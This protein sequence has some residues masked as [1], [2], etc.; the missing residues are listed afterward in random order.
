MMDHIFQYSGLLTI[1]SFI[2]LIFSMILINIYISLAKKLEFFSVP[3]QGGVRQ[4]IIPTSGGISFGLAYILMVLLFNNIH[5][6]PQD[7]L[8][9]IV[10]GSGLM[11][12][13]GFIDDIYSLSSSIRLII[14]LIFV[15]M[16]SFLFGIRFFL[17]LLVLYRT[18]SL[19]NQCRQNRLYF[20]ILK[21]FSN[22]KLFYS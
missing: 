5:S 9:S 7:Y 19:V 20:S 14:Q 6:V 1:S 10:Y 3:H 18:L 15:L 17:S 12:L 11:L 4:D 2:S 16:I 22:A 13:T 21:L 8:S